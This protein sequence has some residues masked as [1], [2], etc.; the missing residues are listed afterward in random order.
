MATNLDKKAHSN[1]IFALLCITHVLPLA[2]EPE[3]IIEYIFTG[4]TLGGKPIR[5]FHAKWT[6]DG[7]NDGIIQRARDAVLDY[8]KV[9]LGLSPPQRLREN[10]FN[11]TLFIP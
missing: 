9:F 7:W 5:N 2:C 1:A 10:Q 3:T 6:L 4:N 8:Y 11:Q